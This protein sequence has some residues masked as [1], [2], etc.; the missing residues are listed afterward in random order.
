M[1]ILQTKHLDLRE[2]KT[3]ARRRAKRVIS[4]V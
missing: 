1:Y 3:A 2:M 4:D